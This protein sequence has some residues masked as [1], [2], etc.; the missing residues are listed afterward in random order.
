VRK[1]P[2]GFAYRV[3]QCLARR[4]REAGTPDIWGEQWRER[5]IETAAGARPLAE[6]DAWC[7]TIRISC[8]L[9]EFQ[10][11]VRKLETGKSENRAG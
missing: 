9:N 6:G 3:R 5:A 1:I 2:E 7:R 8:L 10:A 4:L 11:L